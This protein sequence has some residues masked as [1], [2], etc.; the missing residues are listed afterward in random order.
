[1]H[2]PVDGDLVHRIQQFFLLAEVPVNARHTDIEVLGLMG[3]A[4]RLMSWSAWVLMRAQ[5]EFAN[6][7]TVYDERGKAAV[8]D[9]FAREEVAPKLHIT[10]R[11]AEDEMNFDF[12][13][14]QQAIKRTAHDFLA[15]P[16]GKSGRYMC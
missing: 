7:N 14:D 10:G 5:A 4:R 6:R 1:M 2:E 9:E 8:I 16:Y 11:A 15:D 12:T 3:G 13:D